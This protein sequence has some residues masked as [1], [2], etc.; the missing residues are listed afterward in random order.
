MA[1]IY[2]SSLFVLKCKKP[3]ST[4]EINLSSH[5]VVLSMPL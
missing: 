4:K 5:A 3:I 2:K 1:N